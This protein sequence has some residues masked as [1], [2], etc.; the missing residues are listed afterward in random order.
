MGLEWQKII[1]SLNFTIIANWIN[2]GILV[3][4]LS[5]LLYRPAK[6]FIEKRREKIKSR[7][8]QAKERE[9]SAAELKEER[10]DEL[11]SAREERKEIIN[12]AEKEAAEVVEEGRKKA[13]EEARRIIEQ[14]KAE[15]KQEKEKAREEVEEEYVNLSLLGAEKILRREIDEEDQRRFLDSLL[16]E[17]QSEEIDLQ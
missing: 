3:A 13:K 8:D 17:I 10:L 7:I 14:A 11:K 12:Q 9:K 4:V 6:E 16:E 5:W 2:F 15:A 1:Q